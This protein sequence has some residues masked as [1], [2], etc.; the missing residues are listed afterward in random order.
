[1]VVGAKIVGAFG[2]SRLVGHNILANTLALQVHHQLNL[3]EG[4]NY[5][6]AYFLLV[7]TE[8]DYLDNLGQAVP[9]GVYANHDLS[10]TWC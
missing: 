5:P 1:M 6:R 4:V 2:E 10:K 3:E 8:A 9:L 7:G